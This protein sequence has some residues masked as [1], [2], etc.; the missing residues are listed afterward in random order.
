L[1]VIWNIAP[2]T[3]INAMFI[4]LHYVRFADFYCIT[5]D[6]QF[7]GVLNGAIWSILSLFPQSLYKRK[8]EKQ[9]KYFLLLV[10]MKEIE[11]FEHIKMWGRKCYWFWLKFVVHGRKNL[12]DWPFQLIFFSLLTFELRIFLKM[13]ENFKS[14]HQR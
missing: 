5:F 3:T 11:F 12:K 8:S 9:F 4:C 2:G 7:W 1:I 6:S 13:S 10:E 14:F